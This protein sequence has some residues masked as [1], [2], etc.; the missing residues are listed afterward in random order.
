MPGPADGLLRRILLTGVVP[1]IDKDCRQLLIQLMIA[2]TFPDG[3]ITPSQESQALSQLQTRL[4]HLVS[5][6]AQL[7]GM[8]ILLLFNKPAPRTVK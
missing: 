7:F 6:A 5:K 8:E 1:L 3:K 4:H 2:K